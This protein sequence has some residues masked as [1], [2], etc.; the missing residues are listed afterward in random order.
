MDADPK[1][2]N[3]WLFRIPEDIIEVIKLKSLMAGVQKRLG[4]LNASAETHRGLVNDIDA[5][6]EEGECRSRSSFMRSESHSNSVRPAVC[7]YA[8]SLLDMAEWELRSDEGE[9]V[10][11]QGWCECCLVL[12]SDLPLILLVQATG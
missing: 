2:A 1:S 11:A 3:S 4:D 6:P 8:L 7:T 9:W 5:L 12:L 10:I